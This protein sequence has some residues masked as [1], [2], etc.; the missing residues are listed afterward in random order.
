MGYTEIS[1]A[2]RRLLTPGMQAP[3]ATTMGNT[4]SS[5][6]LCPF[7]AMTIIT[8]ISPFFTVK[9]LAPSV[10]DSYIALLWRSGF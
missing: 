2:H 5:V 8:Q 3:L 1:G 4:K 7:I 6:V 10:S 9:F